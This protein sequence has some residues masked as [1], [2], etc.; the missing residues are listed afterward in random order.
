[1]TSGTN[2]SRRTSMASFPDNLPPVWRSKLAPEAEKPYFKKLVSFLKTERQSKK[3]IFPAQNHILRALQELDLD[4]VR[5]V[6]L[7]QDPY[8]GTGQAIGLSFAVPNELQPKPP[9]LVNIFKEIADDLKVQLP[10]K[11]DLSGWVEQGV[12]LLNT[13]LTVRAHQA[14]SH[15]EQGWETF[16]DQ[17]L[18][19]L[20]DREKPCV[21]L[22]WGTPARQKKALITE[23]RHIILEAPHPSPLS[24]YRG[25]MGCKHFS[26]ANEALQTL[27]ECPIDWTRTCTDY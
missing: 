9:S 16:T 3:P 25:F 6:I 24:A 7:G 4:R 23:S 22:L 18:K 5:V 17:I 8:H 12:L 10:E 2:F 14:F 15:R 11:S 13:V 20:N 27:G 26:K 1:M 19:H 21:F